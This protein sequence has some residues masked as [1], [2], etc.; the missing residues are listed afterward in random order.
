MKKYLYMVGVALFVVVG[1]A[2]FY[3][4]V[5]V[6][7][8]TYKTVSMTKG[9]FTKKIYATGYVG[10]KEYSYITAQSGGKIEYLPFEEGEWIKKGDLLAKI[11][12]VDLPKQLDEARDVIQ[13]AKLELRSLES[14]LGS[15]E[16]KRSLASINHD[17]YKAL[18]DNGVA[19]KAEYDI[20]KSDLVVQKFAYDALRSSID[21]A[22]AEVKRATNSLEGLKQR[23][24]TYEIYS[25]IDALVVQKYASLAQ[26]VASS[27]QI[28]KLV[29]AKNVWVDAYVDE[30]LSGGVRVDQSS[31]ITLR[32]QNSA[33]DGRVKRIAPQSDAITQEREINIAFDELPMPFYINEQAR[34]SIAIEHFDDANIVPLNVICLYDGREGVWVERDLRAYFVP[35]DVVAKDDGVAMV[36]Q[37]VSEQILVP[38]RTKKSLREA[39]RIHL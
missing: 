11:D 18:L 13:K 9:E 12:P 1:G 34:L 32:S 20:A 6:P 25:P 2:M 4:A 14:E 36:R 24:S 39:M 8:T 29:D 38:D 10:A 3:N 27:S 22:K 7:K 23:L 19:T 21:R 31:L 37:S 5:Y 35:L 17:R 15:L 33:I 16:A 26:S 30:R 28:Y